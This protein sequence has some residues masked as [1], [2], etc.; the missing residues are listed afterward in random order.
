MINI[1]AISRILGILSAF[2]T[3]A[4]FIPLTIALYDYFSDYSD[5]NI[6]AMVAIS[7]SIM[8]GYF[9]SFSLYVYGRKS[10]DHIVSAD[11]MALV[12]FSWLVA[13][14]VAAL[15]FFLWG[16]LALG[17]SGLENPFTNYINC[18]F[19]T[20]SGFTTT[21]ASILTNFEVVPDSLMFWR[22]MAVVW[23]TWHR[24]SIRCCAAHDNRKK[25]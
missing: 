7:S 3:T 24:C 13:S 18:I 22:A 20:V 23:W 16:H 2:N 10:S 19:E 6:F 1:Q 14:A 17:S 21:G 15:P 11:A 8:I 4:M 25:S 5:L 12:T 9:I